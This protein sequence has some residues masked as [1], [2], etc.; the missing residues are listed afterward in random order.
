MNKEP[1]ESADKFIVRVRDLSK[2]YRTPASDVVVFESVNLDV[3]VGRLIAVIG[4][5][6]A[7]KSTLL[8]LLGGLDVPTSGHV[9]FQDKDIFAM[10]GAELARFRNRYVG[11]VFQFHHVVLDFL[12][13]V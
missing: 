4:P 10:N 7:G 3:T 5:S 12:F 11:F 9:L 8:H 1:P 2:I 13:V 6:G